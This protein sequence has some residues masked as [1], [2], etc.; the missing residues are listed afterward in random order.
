M[1]TIADTVGS[2][3]V[4]PHSYPSAV[5][6]NPAFQMVTNGRLR[7]FEPKK[8][9]VE[10]HV[11][12]ETQGR[13]D[14]LFDV[15]RAWYAIN[16]DDDFTALLGRVHP[17]DVSHHHSR[18]RAWG[19]LA[20]RQSQDRGLLLGSGMRA[21]SLSPDPTL[22]GWLGFHTR[23]GKLDNWGLSFSATP[24]FIPSLG[25]EIVFSDNAPAYW[26][27][28]ARRVPERVRIE[29]QEYP[30]T[31]RV[32]RSQIWS[33]VILQPQAMGQAWWRYT[34][35]FKGW[36]TASRAPSPDASFPTD[37]YLK[38]NE[39][40]VTAY[41]LVHPKFFPRWEGTLTHEFDITDR[42]TLWTSL[43]A[44]SDQSHGG[45]AGV[46]LGPATFS[47]LHEW[48]PD[49]ASDDYRDLLGQLDVRQE[50]FTDFELYAGLKRHFRQNDLWARFALRLALAK[51]TK[52]DIGTDIFHGSDRSYF[53]EWRANDR[54]FAALQWEL[55]S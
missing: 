19:L 33:D 50:L 6:Y 25:P 53:G 51:E 23:W 43:L 9:E 48:R 5:S 34:K 54:L 31:L 17:Y 24:F 4:E 2:L 39:N 7:W 3:R 49:A 27:R 52:L 10:L 21:T 26:G 42:F 22:M 15:D 28:F 41:A 16:L 38:I 1:A 35:K 44:A 37:S 13:R 8:W 14:V 46:R 30:V 45:E 18:Y 36:F 47:L 29:G 32:D 11:E 40:G 12:A 20:S 55:G